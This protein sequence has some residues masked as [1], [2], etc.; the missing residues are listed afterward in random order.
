MDQKRHIRF[1]E[2]NAADVS[3]FF[4]IFSGGYV[5]NQRGFGGGKTPYSVWGLERQ[6]S[7]LDLSA[8]LF[9][10]FSKKVT[11]RL[12]CEEVTKF[13]RCLRRKDLTVVVKHFL[14]K[15]Y[16]AL[17]SLK[18]LKVLHFDVSN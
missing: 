17:S 14:A 9:F 5:Q 6:R 11:L 10:E 2:W 7:I 8:S 4:N 15:F 13:V 1:G 16:Q 3:K 18:M 12:D